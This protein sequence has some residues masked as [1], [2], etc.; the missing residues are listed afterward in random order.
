MPQNKQDFIT[1]V[2]VDQERLFHSENNTLLITSLNHY[3]LPFVIVGKQAPVK[4]GLS[5]H[6]YHHC[7]VLPGT[8]RDDKD[9]LSLRLLLAYKSRKDCLTSAS[10]ELGVTYKKAWYWLQKS[11]GYRPLM[12]G[13]WRFQT[14]SMKLSFLLVIFTL[15]QMWKKKHYLADWRMV[16]TLMTELGW[17]RYC[18]PFEA[19][20]VPIF[21][22]VRLIFHAG[23]VYEL[24]GGRDGAGRKSI[25]RLR[26]NLA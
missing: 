12:H 14:L 25:E 1:N 8:T 17:V 15:F 10:R 11:Y 24:R 3:H 2:I 7:N 23:R 21:S 20:P 26:K 5:D 16:D 6:T 22:F 19:L 18:F 13:G 9:A 4:N